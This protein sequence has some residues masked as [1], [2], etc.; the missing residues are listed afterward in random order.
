MRISIPNQ[1]RVT[2]PRTDHL[3][4]NDR[5]PV[6]A[7]R[8]PLW[9]KKAELQ[10]LQNLLTACLTDGSIYERGRVLG[11]HRL[12]RSRLGGASLLHK[13]ATPRCALLAVAPNSCILEVVATST[14]LLNISVSSKTFKHVLF[15][16]TLLKRLA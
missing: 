7:H 8:R 16:Y 9:C 15:K 14:A 6:T 2:Y 10:R 1:R 5:A 4:H 13:E 3:A 11:G 12:R